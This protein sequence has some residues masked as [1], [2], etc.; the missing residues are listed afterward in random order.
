VSNLATGRFLAS[1]RCRKTFGEGLALMN[2]PIVP[3][4]LASGIAYTL[5]RS[6]ARSTRFVS[7]RGAK[8]G[9]RD[10]RELLIMSRRL[11]L[12]SRGV[13]ADVFR[14]QRVVH[15]RYR[16][17]RSYKLTRVGIVNGAYWPKVYESNWV[18][19]ID[20]ATGDVREVLDFG[21]LTRTVRS[22][23]RS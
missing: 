4:H 20:P 2:G 3:A 10:R 11:R 9:P 22:Q 21:D 13:A 16:V 19:R 7:I 15:V 8:V 12:A 6:H 5:R 1:R 14:C 17:R 18:L 23:P